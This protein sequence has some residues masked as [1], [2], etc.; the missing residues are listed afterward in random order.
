MARQC[1]CPWVRVRVLSSSGGALGA[2][3]GQAREEE[4]KEEEE[5]VEDKRLH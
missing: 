2:H 1:V 5:E 4:E 3:L